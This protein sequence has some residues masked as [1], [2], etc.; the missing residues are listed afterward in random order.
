MSRNPQALG[1]VPTDVQDQVKCLLSV[2]PDLR[3]DAHQISKVCTVL[4]QNLT[5][6]TLKIVIYF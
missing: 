3:P 5:R 6:R 4:L 2:S 1:G